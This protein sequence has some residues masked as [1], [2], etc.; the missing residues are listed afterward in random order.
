MK[1]YLLIASMS[2]LTSSAFALTASDNADNYVGGWIDGSNGGSGF[3]PWGFTTTDDNTVNIS[4]STAGA[5]DINTVAGSFEMKSD[6]GGS[7][8]VFRSFGGGASLSSGDTFSLDITLNFRDGNKGFDLRNDGDTLFNFNVG[9]DQYIFGGVNL[10]DSAGENWQ[11]LADANYGL[12]F[13]FVTETILNAKIIR[14]STTFGV[15]QYQIPNIALSAVVNN[16]KFYVSGTG[17]DSP[18]NSLYANNLS[19][20]PEP[21]SYAWIAGVLAL[22]TVVRRRQR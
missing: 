14:N 19:V 1:K 16:F 13:E 20:V 17:G 4:D 3:N 5:G 12:E 7:L 22:V 8:D 2:A 15:E 21:S 11:Y 6:N 9:G 10:S 18:D